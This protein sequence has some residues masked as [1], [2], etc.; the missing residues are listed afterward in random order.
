MLQQLEQ[1]I[2]QTFS[3]LTLGS[4]LRAQDYTTEFVKNNPPV[5]LT[6]SKRIEQDSSSLD[7][8]YDDWNQDTWSEPDLTPHANTDT[9][10][11]A[12]ATSHSGQET[13]DLD[14][15]TCKTINNSTGTM[16]RLRRGFPPG[17]TRP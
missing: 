10:A 11:E 3:G 9:H 1:T 5:L 13:V 4:P 8:N 16:H 17:T 15:T 12:G 14:Q 7:H 2:Q 6:N